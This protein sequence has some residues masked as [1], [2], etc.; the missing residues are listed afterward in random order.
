MISWHTTSSL[1]SAMT[2][3]CCISY[4]Q[5]SS[6][7]RLDVNADN[8]A[9]KT[10]PPAKNLQFWHRYM[11]VKPQGECKKQNYLILSE[12]QYFWLHV[13]VFYNQLSSCYEISAFHLPFTGISYWSVLLWSHL[14][15]VI[16]SIPRVSPAQRD[17]VDKR[18]SLSDDWLQREQGKW[19][20]EH[21]RRELWPL[22]VNT[23]LSPAF[24][25]SNYNSA[26]Q[27]P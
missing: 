22:K 14:R 26:G 13:C 4:R 7:R 2:Y 20:N 17:A 8:L 27:A 12:K 21:P 24:I 23:R 10:G 25:W 19:T 16:S 15:S 18:P 5:H 3:M 11:R 9:G 1:F 6:C